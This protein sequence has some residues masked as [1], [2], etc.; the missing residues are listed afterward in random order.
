MLEEA[1]KDF[2]LSL[3]VDEVGKEIFQEIVVTPQ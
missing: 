2:E 3:I 1:R